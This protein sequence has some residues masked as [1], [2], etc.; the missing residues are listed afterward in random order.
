MFENH[1]TSRAERVAVC[2]IRLDVDEAKI[3]TANL[4]STDLYS[5][6]TVYLVDN[7]YVWVPHAV[8]HQV[9]KHLTICKLK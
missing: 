3:S 9:H 1:I 2:W 7:L 5:R 6:V 8:M 4:L